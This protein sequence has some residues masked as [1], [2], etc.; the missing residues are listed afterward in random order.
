MSPLSVRVNSFLVGIVCWANCMSALFSSVLNYFSA[1]H[2]KPPSSEARCS[3]SAPEHNTA[4]VL[5]ACK[6]VQYCKLQRAYF[7]LPCNVQAIEPW[8][9]A[10]TRKLNLVRTGPL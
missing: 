9:L 10:C 3:G 1:T 2:S 8:F 6:C 5:E 7:L 4:Y